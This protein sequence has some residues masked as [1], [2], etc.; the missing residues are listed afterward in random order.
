MLAVIGFLDRKHNYPRRS[1]KIFKEI[2]AFNISRDCEIHN[3]LRLRWGHI[4]IKNVYD[5]ETEKKKVLASSKFD[6]QHGLN[7]A[8]VDLI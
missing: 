6:S 1:Y 8:C 2:N 3:D 7:L 4:F 5:V